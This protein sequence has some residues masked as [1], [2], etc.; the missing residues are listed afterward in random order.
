MCRQNN[1]WLIK[2]NVKDFGQ[3]LIFKYIYI[4]IYIYI[5]CGL[6]IAQTELL[7]SKRCLNFLGPREKRQ[8]GNYPSWLMNPYWLIPHVKIVTWHLRIFLGFYHDIDY[9]SLLKSIPHTVSWSFKE[10]SVPSL[11]FSCGHYICWLEMA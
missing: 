9:L 3:Y 2:L 7:M 1:W 4:Y 11:G 6:V 8:Q 10:N 5:E